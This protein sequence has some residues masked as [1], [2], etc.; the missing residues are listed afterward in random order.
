M[1]QYIKVSF[2]KGKHRIKGKSLFWP[3]K[4][5]DF[6][7]DIIKNFNLGGKNIKINLKMISYELDENA[8]NSKE[9][10]EDY[11]KGNNIKE[12]RFSVEEIKEQVIIKNYEELLD[13]ELLK[14]SE[15]IDVDGIIKDIFYNEEY[16]KKKENEGMKY[17]NNFNQNLEKGIN[18]ILLKKNEEIQEKIN[19]HLSDY[20]NLSMQMHKEEYNTL[21]NIKDNLT[22]IKVS[23]AEVSKGLKN[24]NDSVQNTKK[25]KNEFD[26]LFEEKCIEKIIDIKNASIF[27][28]KD[29]GIINIGKHSLK[30]LFLIKDRAKSSNDFYFFNYNKNGEIKEISLGG[31]FEPNE[32]GTFM[33]SLSISNPKPNQTYKM[34]I[35]VRDK[36]IGKNISEPFE[37]N[38]KFVTQAQGED[39]IQQ[40]QKE[41]E[42]IYK[43]LNFDFTRTIKDD[44]NEE[45][46]EDLENLIDKNEIIEKLMKNNLNKD[47]VIKYFNDKIFDWLERKL[48]NEKYN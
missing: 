22:N 19:K 40:K 34:I 43:E 6:I 7:Q 41:A 33:L 28:I 9:E 35:N 45:Y 30:R 26:I 39:P 38:V 4:Y 42:Q 31:G 10:F 27:Y 25:E 32:S 46:H 20:N 8:I 12:F 47:K 15:E 29:I 44:F 2:Y 14:E 23:S 13:E 21:M 48:L 24:W 16:K 3:Q 1:E 11:M 18:D 17:I 5:E 37:I 36:E